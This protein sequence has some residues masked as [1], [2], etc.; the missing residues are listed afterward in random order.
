MINK[1]KDIFKLNK[2]WFEKNL[3]K[4]LLKIFSDFFLKWLNNDLVW[5]NGNKYPQNPKARGKFFEIIAL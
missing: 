1:R 5:I 3:K 4:E 2:R